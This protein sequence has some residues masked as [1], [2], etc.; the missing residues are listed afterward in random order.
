MSTG[1]IERLRYAIGQL[2]TLLDSSIR[3][4]DEATGPVG[5]APGWRQIQRRDA[6]PVRAVPCISPHIGG[7]PHTLLLDSVWERSILHLSFAAWRGSVKAKM[8]GSC[9][10]V[11]STSSHPLKLRRKVRRERRASG[12]CLEGRRTSHPSLRRT[13]FPVFD[14]IHIP[15]PSNPPFFFSADL[16]PA[17]RAW[18]PLRAAGAR[19]VPCSLLLNRFKLLWNGVDHLCGEHIPIPRRHPSKRSAGNPD[20]G[21]TDTRKFKDTREFEDTPRS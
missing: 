18:K 2:D 11:A 6:P 20:D 13:R 16:E 9:C 7:R 8:T 5:E 3:P 15:F 21:D 19:N 4:E 17:G 12:R 14:I 10:P 1:A